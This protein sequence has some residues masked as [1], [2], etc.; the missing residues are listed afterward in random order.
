MSEPITTAISDR[1]SQHMNADHGDAL[2]LYAQAYGNI[3][4]PEAATLITID[5]QGMNLSVEQQGETI[6]V[7]ILFDH[8]LQDAEDAHH[9][10]IDL[11]KKAR[12][13]DKT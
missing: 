6:P 4:N 10:L 9:T 7:R 13:K 11:I 1:I 2:I 3:P 5:P 12:Q 8:E